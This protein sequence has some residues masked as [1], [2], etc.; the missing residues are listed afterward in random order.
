MKQLILISA[1][2]FEIVRNRFQGSNKPWACIFPIIFVN[3]NASLQDFNT[4][5]ITGLLWNI[6]IK[7]LTNPTDYE[8][9]NLKKMENQ[10]MFSSL[11]Q[12]LTQKSINVKSF[13][14]HE[15]I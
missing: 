13:Q 8:R 12:T 2:I 4:C 6:Y 7:T 9:W 1:F 10:F 14:M 15:K 3:V 11:N 5:F